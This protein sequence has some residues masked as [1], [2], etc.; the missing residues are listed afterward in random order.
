M[1]NVGENIPAKINQIKIKVELVV[2]IS[3]GCLDNPSTWYLLLTRKQ[4]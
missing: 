1:G 4:V 3:T 2:I